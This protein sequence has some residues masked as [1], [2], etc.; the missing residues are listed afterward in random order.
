MMRMEKAPETL[1]AE[2]DQAM[3]SCPSCSHFGGTHHC[4]CELCGD[5]TGLVLDMGHPSADELRRLRSLM[6]HCHNSGHELLVPKLME[7]WRQ[8]R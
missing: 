8:I 6:L 2:M 3:R 7:I 4:D 1:Q 5:V